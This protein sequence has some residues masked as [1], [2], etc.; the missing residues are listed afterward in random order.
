MSS[1]AISSFG[2][3]DFDSFQRQLERLDALKLGTIRSLLNQEEQTLAQTEQ[4]AFNH[5]FTQQMN[6]D[7]EDIDEEDAP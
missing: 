5:N 1:L 7:D 3:G 6:G 2:K 4:T